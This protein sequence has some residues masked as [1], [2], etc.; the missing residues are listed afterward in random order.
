MKIYTYHIGTDSVYRKIHAFHKVRAFRQD[1]QAVCDS[2]VYNSQDSCMTMYKDPIAW[3]GNRQLL[4]E[5]IHAY[6]RD[7]TLRLVHVVGQALSVE[8]LPDSVHYN[9]I[10]SKEMKAHF[11]NGQIRMAE[12]IGNVQTIYYP[13]D[14]KDSSLM[15]LNFLETD[16]MRMYM[17]PQRQ[18]EHIWTNKFTSVMYPMTQIPPTKYKLPNFAWFDDIRPKDKNDIFVWRGKAKG[19]ELKNIK[20]HEAPLQV[21]SKTA[22]VEEKKDEKVN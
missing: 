9:Q 21:L 5:V 15:G 14:D 20:R 18:L 13:V 3:N 1:V 2:L 16:T 10:T 11:L 6:M 4:G 22:A 19:M 17:S 8:M 12:S 7:S